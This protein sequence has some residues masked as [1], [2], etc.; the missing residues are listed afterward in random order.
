MSDGVKPRN[1]ERHEGIPIIFDLS[2]KG[3][4]YW[5]RN[6]LRYLGFDPFITP[7]RHD[8]QI[9]IYARLIQGYIVTTDKG[10]RKCKRAI[11]LTV[12]KYEKMYV[13]MLKELHEKLVSSVTTT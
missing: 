13:R 11:I 3:F 1:I 7:Y 4:Y 8:H 6:R 9:M 12:D 10:F 5:C 2:L